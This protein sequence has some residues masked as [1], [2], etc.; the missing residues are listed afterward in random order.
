MAV[1]THADV[2]YK[3]IGCAMTVHN[4]LGPGLREGMYQRA[5]AGELDRAGLIHEEEYAVE[6]ALGGYPIGLLYLD[7]LVE[8]SVIVE[9]K[10][11]RHRITNDEI[12][13]VVTYLAATGHGVAI[14]LNFGGKSLEYRR[15]LPPCKLN[16]W[17]TR[18]RRYVWNPPGP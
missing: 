6:V 2:T 13:Q 15:I 14:L 12:G 7:H 3:I 18:I 17:K 5:L 9:L 10:A 16:E 4:A 1:I 8:G 11:L